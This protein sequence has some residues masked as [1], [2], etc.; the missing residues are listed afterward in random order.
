MGK[1]H[2]HSVITAPAYPAEKLPVGI[3]MQRSLTS[4]FSDIPGLLKLSWP[5]LLLVGGLTYVT[6]LYFFSGVTIPVPGSTTPPSVPLAT[7]AL[8]LATQ[9]L[10]VLAGAAM[11]VGWH[12]KV[13]LAESPGAGS[14]LPGWPA[15]RYVGSL[16]LMILLFT[17]PIWVFVGIMSAVFMPS[18]T[19]GNLVPLPPVA[20]LFVLAMIPIVFCILAAMLRLSLVLPARA[21]GDNA[22]RFRDAWAAT[23]GNTLRLVFGMFLTFVVPLIVVQMLVMPFFM[24]SFDK[25]ARTPAAIGQAFALPSA[26]MTALTLLISMMGISF[27][28]YSYRHFF[29]ARMAQ[30]GRGEPVA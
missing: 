30:G 12:R 16:T 24:S 3:T 25:G 29:G 10:T 4:L 20:G 22:L 2:C 19:G 14:F 23:R 18:A 27:L 9:F 21:I 1:L 15:L 7:Q 8:S 26:I 5:W 28:S 17:V 6:T 11:A 13:L